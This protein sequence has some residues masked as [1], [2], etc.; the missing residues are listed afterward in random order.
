MLQ[1]YSEDEIKSIKP[2]NLKIGYEADV[3]FENESNVTYRYTE[4]DG[5]IVQYWVGVYYTDFS[6][7]KH[8]I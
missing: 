3:I 1:T 5:E 4:V 7:L 6:K 2:K 8:W